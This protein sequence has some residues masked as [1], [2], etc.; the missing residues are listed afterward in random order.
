MEL[1]MRECTLGMICIFHYDPT[2][3]WGPPAHPTLGLHSR[4]IDGL[5]GQENIIH[6][7]PQLEVFPK[8]FSNTVSKLCDRLKS[9]DT[10]RVLRFQMKEMCCYI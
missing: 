5:I 7:A 8:A 1:P 4:T 2:H 9:D 3:S 10:V 6:W